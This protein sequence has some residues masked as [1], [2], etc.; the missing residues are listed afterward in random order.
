MHF[1]HLKSNKLLCK[2]LFSIEVTVILNKLILHWDIVKLATNAWNKIDW[3]LQL[4]LKFE[5]EEQKTA[6]KCIETHR[7]AVYFRV[8]RCKI[9]RNLSQTVQNYLIFHFANCKLLELKAA[10]FRFNAPKSGSAAHY[11]KHWTAHYI[12]KKICLL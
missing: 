9:R 7:K 4:I 12:D 2:K 8:V 6:L 1:F 11:S 5:T 10:K 3:Q